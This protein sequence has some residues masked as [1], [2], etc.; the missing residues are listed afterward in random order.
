MQTIGTALAAGRN[1]HHH[2]HHQV[3]FRPLGPYY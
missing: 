2:H 1:H 3:Y